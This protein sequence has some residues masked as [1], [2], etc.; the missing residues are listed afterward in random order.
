MPSLVA[1]GAVDDLPE[2]V[3]D[4]AAVVRGF[5]RWGSELDDSTIPNATGVVALAASF[6]KGCYT[7][8]ELVERIDSRGGNVPKRLVGVDFAGISNAKPGDELVV[9]SL[10]VARLTSVAVDPRTG[11]SVGL[12]YAKREVVDGATIGAVDGVTAE[13]RALL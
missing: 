2:L 12:A 9:D 11:R 5:P 3:S 6:T 4:I 1:D 7:G 8:Q 10:A 13:V